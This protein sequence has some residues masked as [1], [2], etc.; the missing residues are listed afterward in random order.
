MTRRFLGD[1]FAYT[2]GLG[3]WAGLCAFAG[4]FGFPPPKDWRPARVE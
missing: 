3:L 2:I 4:A 1:L